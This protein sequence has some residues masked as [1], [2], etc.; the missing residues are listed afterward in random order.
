VA[1]ARWPLC[2]VNGAL[3]AV[4]AS[5][6]DRD[7]AQQWG[8]VARADLDNATAALRLNFPV[9]A[10]VGGLEGLPGGDRFFRRFAAERGGQRLGKG[11]PLNPDLTPEAAGG[12]IE[13]AA[14]W[15][16]GRLLPY[17][18]FRQMRAE[19]DATENAA[20]FRFLVE[21][22]RRAPRLARLV[23][24]MATDGRDAPVF[25]GCYVATAADGEVQFLKEFFKKVEAAQAAVA[26]T[27]AA[28]VEDAAYR[29]R[30]A[31]GYAVLAIEAIVVAALA[32]YT[33]YAQLRR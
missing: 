22:R 1:A 6:A 15:A 23:S 32:A 24:R 14:A 31:M 25:G 3:V 19:A 18:V 27:D 9:F 30:A 13:T 17:H 8:L 2:P 28:Y 20:L 4:P 12:E 11:F 26:W 33:V 29:S 16:V 7:D 21:L 10:L 5:A